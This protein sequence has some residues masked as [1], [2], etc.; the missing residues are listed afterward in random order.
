MKK[1]ILLLA[2]IF[3]STNAIG[4][5]PPP[6]LTLYFALDYNN[7]GFT[8]FNINY[9]TNTYIQNK[10]LA[11]GYN[12]SGYNLSFFPSYT[13]YINNTNAIQNTYVN[14]V[15]SLQECFLKLNYSGTGIAYD[16]AT[17][18]FYFLNINL[19]T[20]NHDQDDD[21]D[22]VLN[23][24]EDLNND[25][26]LNNEDTDLDG[27]LNFNDSDDDGDGVLTI[28]EDYN[29]NG[30][31]TD[32]DI[33]SNG[34]ADY[35]DNTVFLN[36]E[37]FLS[38]AEVQIYPNPVQNH[39]TISSINPN[40]HSVE[41]F[42]MNGKSIIIKNEDISKLDLSGFKSGVYFLKINWIDKSMNFKIVKT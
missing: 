34:I 42:D 16:Q 21:N 27:I 4:Q 39:L 11:M 1:I 36:S 38:N 13:D 20:V 31:V 25:T 12:L 7:D 28:N 24:F 37:S 2:L 32:D 26:T 8:S 10:A 41:I 19:K 22:S 40:Y 6:G 14:Q 9:F 5:P 30:T 15:N 35:L 18:D 33:N 17:L 3:S 29:L 23:K